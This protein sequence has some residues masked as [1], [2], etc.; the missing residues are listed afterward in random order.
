MCEYT[1]VDSDIQVAGDQ[2]TIWTNQN[3]MIT[4][5]DKT[6]QIMIYFGWQELTL[7]HL[8]IGESEIEHVKLSK[9]LGLMINNKHIWH[10]HVLQ[11]YRLYT[12][13]EKPN[14][15]SY[16]LPWKDQHMNCTTNEPFKI[17]TEIQ[18]IT[19]HLYAI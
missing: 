12:E 11:M 5:T 16:L 18:K 8:K 19:N 6:K 3:N 7:P 1:G 9:L 10:D 15:V 14:I 2:G 4:N 17:K 13:G